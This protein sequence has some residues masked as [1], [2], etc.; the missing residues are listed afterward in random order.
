MP[1]KSKTQLSH[2]NAWI[3]GGGRRGTAG[4]LDILTIQTLKSATDAES[5]ERHFD[6]VC[7]HLLQS[8]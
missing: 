6:A 5:G 3:D 7:I 1:S 2:K 4:P 8:P